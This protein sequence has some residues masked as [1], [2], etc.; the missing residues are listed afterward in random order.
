MA[1]LLHGSTLQAQ[2]PS[3]WVKDAE[4]AGRPIEESGERGPETGRSKAAG[5]LAAARLAAGARTPSTLHLRGDSRRFVRYVSVKSPTRIEER[6]RELSGRF[7]F[8]FLLPDRFRIRMKGETLGGYGFKFEEIVNGE[9][10]WRNPPLKVRSSNSDS[11]VIDVGDV[12]RTLLM[13]TQSARQQ[14]AFHAL[15]IL[16]FSPSSYPLE[17]REVGLFEFAGETFDSALAATSDGLLLNL[18]FDRQTRLLV[19]LAASY[20]DTFQEAVI[21]EVA[22][23]DRRFISS[24]YARA[25]EERRRRRH[26]RQRQEVVWRFTDHRQVSGQ[27]IPHRFLVYFNGRL[28]EENRI[29]RIRLDEP[30]D[31]RRFEGQERVRY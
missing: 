24:T 23:V 15:G 20:L 5:L 16:A 2:S 3:G 26:P 13:Q 31:G 6:E 30:I 12:E 9:R 21:A 10:A 22:S 7:E 4:S 28:I 18:L 14:A 19:G 27:L 11:R 1:P 17:L 25:R 29:T 8:D